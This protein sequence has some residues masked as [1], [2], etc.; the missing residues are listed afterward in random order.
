MVSNC[1]C[2]RDAVAAT[3]IAGIAVVVV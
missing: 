3:A 2:D 1:A